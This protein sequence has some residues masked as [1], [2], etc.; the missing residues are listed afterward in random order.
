MQQGFGLGEVLLSMT[1][2]AGNAVDQVREILYRMRSC[3]IS[4]PTE[5][6]GK[7]LLRLCHGGQPVVSQRVS[8]VLCLS[9]ACANDAARRV[10]NRC[11]G[12]ARPQGGAGAAPPR[13]VPRSPRRLGCGS[14][15]L[16]QAWAVF[17]RPNS[18]APCRSRPATCCCRRCRPSEPS[19]RR[20]T[21]SMCSR[22]R[23]RRLRSSAAPTMPS[24]SPLDDAV[25]AIAADGR[26]GRAGGAAAVLRRRVA[27][28]RSSSPLPGTLFA[29]GRRSSSARS[30]R[31]SLG[32]A[33]GALLAAPSMAPLELLRAVGGAGATAETM[34]GERGAA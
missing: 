26:A 32:D 7:K 28:G 12:C 25:R 15:A 22:A 13:G 27:G 23:R 6:G 14:A 17:V 33:V 31:A 11:R 30:R 29:S 4:P 9:L 3:T 24:S 19:R 8:L 20:A 5:R 1:G 34:L 21:R 10:G 16:R 2:G 18:R